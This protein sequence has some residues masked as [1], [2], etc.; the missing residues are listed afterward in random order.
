V[1]VVGSA[2]E[3][4]GDCGTNKMG[5]AYLVVRS[6]NVGYRV[7]TTVDRWTMVPADGKQHD[8]LVGDKVLTEAKKFS[9]QVKDFDANQIED[10]TKVIG[11]CANTE[12]P[13]CSLNNGN[14]LSATWTTV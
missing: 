4:G 11:P 9:F 5:R 1:T 14:R 6:G 12:G 2:Y 10:I 13:S 8:V 3:T 7:D